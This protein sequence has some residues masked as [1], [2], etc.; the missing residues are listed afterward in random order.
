MKTYT[1]TPDFY[2]DYICHYNHNHDPRNGQFTSGNGNSALPK[3]RKFYSIAMLEKD[4]K[5]GRRE[6]TAD[7][8]R[9][10]S[11]NQVKWAEK[12]NPGFE[13]WYSEKD[14]NYENYDVKNP[15][16]HVEEFKKETAL[17]KAEEDL[18]FFMDDGDSYD[19]YIKSQISAYDEYSKIF[20]KETKIAENN[21]DSAVKNIIPKDGFSKSN[22]EKYAGIAALL[23][24]YYNENSFEDTISNMWFYKYEDGDQ[25]RNNSAMTQLVSNYGY[26]NARKRIENYHTSERQ[27]H[28][29][30]IEQFDKDISNKLINARSYKDETKTNWFTYQLNDGE[31]SASKENYEKAIK[32]SKLLNDAVPF[33]YN[34]TSSAKQVANKIESARRSGLTYEQIA[35]KYGVS[36]S[37]IGDV[38]REAGITK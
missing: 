28:E 22:T 34:V 11:T 7:E 35:D 30:L 2:R 13:R 38:L 31:M 17:K 33:N 8:W 1:A 9:I 4:V 5:T 24:S 27:F 16:K 19:N 32:M 10:L 29:A 36:T 18:K 3:P 14:P 37:F 20:N 25:G 21:L 6:L 12:K 15:E 23:N 26:D